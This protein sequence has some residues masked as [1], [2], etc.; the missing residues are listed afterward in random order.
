M[1]RGVSVVSKRRFGF[2]FSLNPFRNAVQPDTP[3]RNA[4]TSADVAAL[5]QDVYGTNNVNDDTAMRVSAVYACVRLLS[6]SVGFLPLSLFKK[7]GDTHAIAEKHPAHSLMSYRPNNWQ[8]PFEFE[9]LMTAHKLLRGNAYA[10]KTTDAKGNTIALTPLDPTK[11]V[12]S[13]D[14]SLNL[15]YD[16]RKG[17]PKY[18]RF[19]QS[20]IHHRRGLTRDGLIGLSPITAASRAI[21]LAI[22]AENHGNQVFKN[23]ARP[24]GALKHPTELS[25]A[26]F[27]RVQDSFQETYG[28]EANAGKTMILESGLE[29]VQMG[30][31][32]EDLQFMEGRKLQRNEIAMFYGVPPHM[33]GD[34]ER[35]TSWGSGIEQQNIGFLIYTLMP[36]LINDRQALARDVLKPEE[37]KDYYFRHD[38]SILERA[39]FLTRQQGFEIQYNNGVI[40]A[41]DWRKAEGL[42]P[43]P[44]GGGKVYA[45]GPSGKTTQPG[46]GNGGSGNSSAN[47]NDPSTDQQAA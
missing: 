44:D 23:A 1:R 2:N 47:Q 4:R 28:G 22:S 27:K 3:A 36:H 5:I 7:D 39:E 13:Q 32:A 40:C 35:G 25:D 37:L 38:T 18:R 19:K 29:W 34:I 12:V 9:S 26:A 43:R 6:N 33:I 17:T 11:M 15:V 24:S 31:S 46:A 42:N 41:D 30:M 20:E 10:Y 21:S 14:D 8:T 45:P 16:Y